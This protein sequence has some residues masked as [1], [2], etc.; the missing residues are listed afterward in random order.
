MV[1]DRGKRE[2]REGMLGEL[3]KE[4]AQRDIHPAWLSKIWLSSIT[5]F[6]LGWLDVGAWA[7]LLRELRP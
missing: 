3:R 4:A 5:S 2:E 6:L 1:N 7:G